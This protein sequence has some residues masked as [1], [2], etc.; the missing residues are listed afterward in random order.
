M[1][2]RKLFMENSRTRKPEY[3]DEPVFYCKHCLSL[4]IKSAGLPDLL[5]CDKCSNTDIGEVDIEEWE[6]L[7]KEKYG[8]NYLND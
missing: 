6:K 1:N 3:D 5:Y 2:E 8:F 7:H 4:N